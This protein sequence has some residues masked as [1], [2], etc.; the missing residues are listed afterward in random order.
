MQEDDKNKRQYP[1]AKP[2]RAQRK[3]ESIKHHKT[4]H[5]LQK[6]QKKHFHVKL[7]R[8]LKK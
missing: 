1:H 5:T 3:K 7:R 2:Q 8:L 6:S 4:K